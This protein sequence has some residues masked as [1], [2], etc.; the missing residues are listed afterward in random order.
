MF[1]YASAKLIGKYSL[2][3][4]LSGVAIFGASAHAM[5]QLKIA[6]DSRR[7][8]DVIDWFISFFVALFAG[9]VSG[10]IASSFD[11]TGNKLFLAV[12][13]GSFLGLQGLNRIVEYGIKLLENF[14]K[15]R[16]K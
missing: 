11:Y 15:I 12:A 2:L 8:Y 16:E 7:K 4:L 6:R 14:L 13:M 3:W 9:M 5:V 10:L 1:E